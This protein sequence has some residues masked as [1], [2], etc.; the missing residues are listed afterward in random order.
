MTLTISIRGSL[1]SQG[2]NLIYST[3]IQKLAT[4]ALAIPEIA[5]VEIENGSYN[6]DHA[7]FKGALSFLCWALTQ[8]I[9]CIQNMTTLASVIPKIWL[10]P[11]KI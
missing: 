5:G 11:T 6:P 7:P 9:T 3:Y 1:S 8:P 10:V 2:Q 4:L